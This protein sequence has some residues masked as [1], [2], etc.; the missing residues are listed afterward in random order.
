MAHIALVERCFVIVSDVPVLRLHRFGREWGYLV[1]NIGSNVFSFC[2]L[3]IQ[4]RAVRAGRTRTTTRLW[5]ACRCVLTPLR[6][7]FTFSL[8]HLGLTMSFDASRQFALAY[9]A[10]YARVTL[11]RQ[12]SLSRRCVVVVA[13]HNALTTQRRA[14]ASCFAV[15]SPCRR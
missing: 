11:P 3:S 8:S 6:L 4:S 1:T 2:F 13:S 12:R 7:S 15:Q 5:L 14:N 10:A 9:L